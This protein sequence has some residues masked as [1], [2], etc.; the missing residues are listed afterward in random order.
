M[1]S[2][3]SNLCDLCIE[4]GDAIQALKDGP[5]KDHL[6]SLAQRFDVLID[7]ATRLAEPLKNTAPHTTDTPQ[8]T[9][10]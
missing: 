10:P 7:R 2:I 9:H 8:E 6:G 5:R 3:L 4:F 1:P